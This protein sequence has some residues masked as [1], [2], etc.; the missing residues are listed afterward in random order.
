MPWFTLYVA[1][2]L[3]RSALTSLTFAYVQALMTPSH[4]GSFGAVPPKWSPSSTVTTK[5]ELSFVIPSLCIRAKNLANASS[6]DLSWS[7]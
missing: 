6:Y 4:V 3:F 1:T 5:S 2:S 7:T